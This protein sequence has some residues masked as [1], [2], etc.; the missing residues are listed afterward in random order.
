[1]RVERLGASRADTLRSAVATL[2]A[3]DVGTDHLRAFLSDERNYV[4]AAFDA[5]RLIGLA[6]AFALPVLYGGPGPLLFL[7]E[8][9]VP[10][11]DRRR[12]AGRALVAAFERVC[13][14]KRCDMFVIT[15][16]S[17]EAAMGLYAAAGGRRPNPDDVMFVFPWGGE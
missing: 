12:G 13:R 1:M 9:D 7:Y 4:F 5:D 10:A 8:I 14:E 6:H 3:K 2:Y 11:A 15:E 17:N 16:A